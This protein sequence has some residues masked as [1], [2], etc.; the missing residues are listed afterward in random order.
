MSPR[1]LRMD[2][3][4]RYVKDMGPLIRLCAVRR[5]EHFQR[6]GVCSAC[7]PAWYGGA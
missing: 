6:A 3:K 5:T 1:A 2:H 7:L 4:A